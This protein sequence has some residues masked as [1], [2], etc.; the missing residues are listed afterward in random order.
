MSISVVARLPST[1]LGYV[2]LDRCVALLVLEVADAKM[3]DLPWVATRRLREYAQRTGC[4]LHGFYLRFILAEYTKIFVPVAVFDDL[5]SD[6]ELFISFFVTMAIQGRQVFQ[7]AHS[8][9][10]V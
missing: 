1:S 6:P 5:F 9:V 7:I 10:R 2:S 8:D 3:R 4:I